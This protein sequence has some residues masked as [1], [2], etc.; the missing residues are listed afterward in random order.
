MEGTIYSILPPLVAIIC[1]LFT[2]R[3]ILSLGI[4]V[5]TATF[6]LSWGKGSE[7]ISLFIQ[8]LFSPFWNEEGLVTANL[9][10][11]LFIL[12][13]GALTALIRLSGGTE[14]FAQ[15]AIQRVK[16]RRGAKLLTVGLGILFFIDDYFN[17]LAVGQIAKPV[18]DQHQISRAQ[19]AY[20][21]D[22]TSAPVCVVSPISSWGAYLIG[23]L[24]LIFG[25]TAAI[26][27][28]PIQA[29]VLMAPMN[30][31]VVTTLAFVLFFAW[32]DFSLF[33]MRQHEIKA[34]TTGELYDSTRSLPGELKDDF[35]ASTEGKVS[36]LMLPIFVLIGVSLLSMGI[37]GFLATDTFS[38]LALFEEMNVPFSLLMGGIA[39]VAV[40]LLINSQQKGRRKFILLATK[41]GLQSMLGAVFILYFAWVLTDLIGQLQTGPYLAQVVLHFQ[42]STSFLPMILFI[43][44]GVIAFSTGTSWGSFGILLPIAAEI[45]IAAN[46]ELLLPALSAV[47]AGA[48]FGDHTSPISDTT[49]LSSTGAGSHLMDHVTTQ[50][51]YTL[52]SA[53][54]AIAGYLTLAVT[55]SI[56]LGLAVVMGITVMI[57]GI[58]L[59]YKHKIKVVQ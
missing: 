22:S 6:I 57:M 34:V 38:V 9:Y 49:I 25:A 55:G 45:M 40:S 10:I 5:L 20:F 53:S 16:T 24:T 12:L 29:F 30:F 31:Y 51:P 59:S 37:T 54:V 50:L 48:V 8:A 52:L 1:V 33:S 56:W 36:G 11:I 35:P 58:L 44:G 47:L 13:L 19:L 26:A 23:Q 7:G 27:Y 42:I 17:A 28:S 4:G 18:T 3:V 14:A 43:L 2:K 41:S 15:W 21:I 39:S 32:T 46:I